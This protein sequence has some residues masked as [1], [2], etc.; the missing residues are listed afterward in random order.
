[1]LY[2]SAV[3]LTLL[4]SMRAAYDTAKALTRS[5]HTHARTHARTHAHMH[6]LQDEERELRLLEE[7][8]AM[9]S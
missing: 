8:M 2:R 3:P 6:G 5:T 9:A 4:A 7:S 1:M